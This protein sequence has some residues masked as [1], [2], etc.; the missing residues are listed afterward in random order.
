LTTISNADTTL[1]N[2]WEQC[3]SC[4][5]VGI[6]EI[7]QHD[8]SVFMDANGVILFSKEQQFD[9]MKI[10]DLAGRIIFSSNHDLYFNKYINVH[11]NPAVI[12]LVYLK[13]GIKS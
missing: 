3:S 12:Y 2:I 1:C 4:T 8:I 13:R 7:N 6:N 11:L 9:E 10:V 5:P